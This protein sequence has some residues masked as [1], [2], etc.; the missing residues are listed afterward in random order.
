M[1]PWYI[2]LGTYPGELTMSGDQE[3]LSWGVKC[4]LRSRRKPDKKTGGERHPDRVIYGL[5]YM[6]LGGQSSRFKQIKMA[7]CDHS[8]L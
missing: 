8:H 7:G 5:L 2:Q 1:S 4:K 3:R 6:A